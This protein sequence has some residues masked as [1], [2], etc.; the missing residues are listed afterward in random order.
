MAK[1]KES[2]FTQGNGPKIFQL[3]KE[4]SALMQESLSVSDY[5]TRFKCLWDELMEFNQIPVCSCGALQSC[6]CGACD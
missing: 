2:V 4:L 6:S 5:Y 3:Q 1:F